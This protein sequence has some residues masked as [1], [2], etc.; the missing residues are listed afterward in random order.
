MGGKMNQLQSNT[1]NEIVSLH[2]EIEVH[3][4][5]SLTKAIRI[6]ELLTE[7]KQSIPH[8]QFTFWIADN[9]PFTDRT[10]RNY[11]KVYRQRDVLKTENVSVL[12]E[13]Y[14][15]LTDPKTAKSLLDESRAYFFVEPSEHEKFFYVT[16][17]VFG[18]GGYVEG[19]KKP[20]SEDA[21][22]LSLELLKKNV[23]DYVSDPQLICTE[24][25]INFNRFLYDSYD[26]YREDWL[27]GGG[28]TAKRN[29]CNQCGGNAELCHR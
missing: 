9:L 27:N 17:I 28:S 24:Q 7:Q 19:T 21:L 16:V 18:D 8:G 20:I 26:E 12:S 23:P 2:K 3:F 1:V 22:E 10:A 15:L 11:M 5:Q 4:R 29:I 14:K 13:G 25:P 6:G